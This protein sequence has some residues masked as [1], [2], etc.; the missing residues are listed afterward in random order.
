MV[1]WFL[2]FGLVGGIPRH[3]KDQDLL[4]ILNGVGSVEKLWYSIAVALMGLLIVE[5]FDQ[6]WDV[7]KL[8]MLFV[9]LNLL[10]WRKQQFKN[11]TAPSCKV[12][13]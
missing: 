7:S 13:L 5:G 12:V 8:L 3:C 10:R 4:P 11:L 6:Q 9:H 1:D 2:N